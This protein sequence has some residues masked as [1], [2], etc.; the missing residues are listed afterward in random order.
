MEKVKLVVV[1][2]CA[3]GK[4]RFGCF[5]CSSTLILKSRS[6]LIAFFD[7]YFVADYTPTGRGVE[8]T[9]W[10][11]DNVVKA[12]LIFRDKRVKSW[13]GWD[14]A[15]QEEYAG[16]RTSC[17][18]GTK[19]FLLVFSVCARRSFDSLTSKWVPELRLSGPPN[20]PI[21]LVGTHSDRRGKEGGKEIELAEI[22]EKVKEMGAIGYVE[23][24]SMYGTGFR[25]V[26]DTAMENIFSDYG[27]HPHILPKKH[28]R[29]EC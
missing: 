9:Q 7:G 24:S 23:C 28:K 5:V 14:T 15:G 1:G 18:P 6:L 19:I 25:E 13:I 12:T 10:E 8:N 26:F 4:T 21:L 11:L 17:Y 16:R 2:D 20:T 29:E 3:T 22:Q 27:L